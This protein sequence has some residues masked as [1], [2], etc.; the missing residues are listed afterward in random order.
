MLAN[1]IRVSGKDPFIKSLLHFDGVA[2]GNSITDDTGKIWTAGGSTCQL[3]SAAKIGTA[4]LY[5]YDG[6]L[7]TPAHADFNFGSNDFTVE[8][9]VYPLNSGGASFFCGQGNNTGSTIVFQ[10]GRWGDNKFRVT[11][12][13]GI[14]AYTLMCNTAFAQD[15]WYHIAVVRYGNNIYMYVN[16][17]LDGTMTWSYSMPSSSYP[18][19]IGKGD[20]ASTFRW[21]GY[22]DEFRLSNGKARYT[23]NFTPQTTPFSLAA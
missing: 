16:G 6:L 5:L 17:N 11:L 3:T 19:V 2:G 13:N 8:L 20:S 14:T 12:G 7:T 9:W 1:K 23:G 15:A 18:L 22:I 10:M 21:Y 4:S